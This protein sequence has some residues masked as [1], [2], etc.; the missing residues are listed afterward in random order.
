MRSDFEVEQAIERYGDT[1]M[2]LCMIYL[3]NDADSQ[4][5]FQTVF[6]KYALCGVA[7]ESPEHEQSWLVRVTINACKDLC[8]SFFRRRTVSLEEVAG[9]PEVR[10][11]EYREVLEA[12][13]GLPEK[14]RVAIYL[15][16]YEGYTAPEIGKLTGRNVNTVYTLLNR[17]KK[18]LKEALE[19]GPVEQYIDQRI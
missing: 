4:D 9:L 16:Y 13:L 1:V 7:F 15:H 17:G 8:R 14:Y 19:D 5:I 11:P 6:L 12:V 10:E 18:M 3:K 2:R